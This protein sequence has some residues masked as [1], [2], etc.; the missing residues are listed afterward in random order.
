[1]CARTGSLVGA[2]DIVE[3]NVPKLGSISAD[4]SRAEL[5]SAPNGCLQANT[6]LL[7]RFVVGTTDDRDSH[8]WVLGE[9]PTE[10]C[11]YCCDRGSAWSS[12]N[13]AAQTPTASPEHQHFTARNCSGLHGRETNVGKQYGREMSVGKQKS[14]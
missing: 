3:R 5:S 9:P 14:E 2:D 11:T 1:M 13:V 4:S 6:V 7:D 8:M 12:F 10:Y